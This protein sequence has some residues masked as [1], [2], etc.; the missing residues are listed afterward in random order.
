MDK[1]CIGEMVHFLKQ[2]GSY[3]VAADVAAKYKDEDL[4]SCIVSAE[5]G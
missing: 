3:D 2:M 4:E 5:I 1:D